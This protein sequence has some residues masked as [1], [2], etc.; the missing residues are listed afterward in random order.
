MVTQKK[1]QTLRHAC[2]QNHR[3]PHS[4]YI[5]NSTLHAETHSSIH[6]RLHRPNT[7]LLSEP[8]SERHADG[9][10]NAPF[11]AHSHTNTTSHREP[12]TA[13]LPHNAQN[14]TQTTR[15]HTHTVCY[16]PTTYSYTLVTWS[17]S[18]TH[19]PHNYAH[20]HADA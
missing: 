18:H 5:H 6:S 3:V 11:C 9:T 7:Q 17:Q 14:H 8:I 10:G 2:R 12:Q 16:T 19:Q 4:Y 1:V 20:S 15:S 13:Y